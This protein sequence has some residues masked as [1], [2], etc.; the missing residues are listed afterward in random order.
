MALQTL[1]GRTLPEIDYRA[2]GHDR[3]DD[4]VSAGTELNAMRGILFGVV[5]CIPFWAAVA[6]A[7]WDGV[8]S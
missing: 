6:W 4:E 8:R 7:V 5:L 2:L 1:A 3:A